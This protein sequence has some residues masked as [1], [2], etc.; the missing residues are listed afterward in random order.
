MPLEILIPTLK[1]GFIGWERVLKPKKRFERWILPFVAVIHNFKFF[2]SNIRRVFRFF[3]IFKKMDYSEY[4]FFYTE[5]SICSAEYSDY[6]FFIFL[7]KS[8]WLFLVLLINPGRP[9]IQKIISCRSNT[10]Y[11]VE[12]LTA[13]FLKH[14]STFYAFIT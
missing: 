14:F 5:C 8:F 4:S 6:L 10:K 7:A 13:I 9:E 12:I 2:I 3:V 1:V 11:V